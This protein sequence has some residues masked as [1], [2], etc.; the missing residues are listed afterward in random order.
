MR[1]IVR[2]WFGRVGTEQDPPKPWL[3]EYADGSC[4]R[5]SELTLHGTYVGHYHPTGEPSL[6]ESPKAYLELK[7]DEQWKDDSA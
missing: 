2:A 5:L 7:L 4:E 3:V 6:V 1:K